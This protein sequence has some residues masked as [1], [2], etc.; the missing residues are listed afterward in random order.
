VQL[1]RDCMRQVKN[2]R[3]IRYEKCT[4]P[5]IDKNNTIINFIYDGKNRAITG[6]SDKLQIVFKRLQNQIS[7]QDFEKEI[8]SI[9]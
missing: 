2:N 5:K 3:R 4:S 7:V 6:Q 9:A 8:N 1:E